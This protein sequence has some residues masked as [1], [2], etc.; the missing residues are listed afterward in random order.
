[1]ADLNNII[2]TTVSLVS[3]KLSLA[4]VV[5]QESLQGDLPAL[6]CD[7]SQIQQVVMNL[8]M[9]AA[10]STSSQEGGSVQ[11]R[12]RLSEDKASIIMEVQD[13]GEGIPAEN[14]TKIFNPFFTTK[15]EVKGVGLGLAVV[16]GV[17]NAHGG[18]VEVES[19]VGEGTTFRVTL[20][21]DGKS[22]PT[23]SSTNLETGLLV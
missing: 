10:E 6:R 13:D 22:D 2:R 3:H 7:S 19:T 12:T 17:I 11:V 9:N 14:L 5:V 23:T 1:M 8:V 20:P 18:D 21:L 4:N 15:G 16:Y